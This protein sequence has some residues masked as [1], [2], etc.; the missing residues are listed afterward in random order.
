M[1]RARAIRSKKKKERWRTETEGN[2]SPGTEGKTGRV[3][4]GEAVNEK[5]TSLS[6]R[7]GTHT[8]DVGMGGRDRGGARG[9]RTEKRCVAVVG[10]CGRV[11]W[12]KRDNILL[13][14][15]HERLLNAGGEKTTTI[16]H[17]GSQQ[18]E[19]HVHFTRR[20][21]HRRNLSKN[22]PT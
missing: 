9:K 6:V 11:V 14:E 5:L 13:G 8:D 20:R 17:T 2:K 22:A 7:E 1:R 10:E 15:R 21:P 12:K 16:L 18:H 19:T 4:H 3:R